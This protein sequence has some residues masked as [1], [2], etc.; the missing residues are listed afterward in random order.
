L[1]VSIDSQNIVYTRDVLGY[2]N[3]TYLRLD[4]RI[5]I[6]N[7][8]TNLSRELMNSKPSRYND[9]DVKFSPNEEEVIYTNSS[10]DGISIKK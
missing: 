9:L 8:E 6:H 4:F 5:F 10:N 1:N 2:Q 7:K 3:S